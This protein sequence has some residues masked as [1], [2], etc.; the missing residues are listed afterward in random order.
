M[1]ESM[2]A[3]IDETNRRRAGPD[4][5]QRGARHRAATIVKEIHDIN[6]RLRAVAESTQVYAPAERPAT[7]A[8]LGAG[9]REQ[10]ERLVSQ[11]EAEMKNAAKEL[12]FERAAAL[13]DEI[14]Q[15]DCVCSR[16]TVDDRRAG[17]RERGAVR[18]EARTIETLAPERVAGAGGRDENRYAR[19]R[20]I[21][22]PAPEAPAY[23]VTSVAVLPA[24]EEPAATLDGVPHDQRRRGRRRRHRAPTASDWLPGIRDE[25]EED[26]GWQARWTERPTWD[27]TVTPN[28]IRRTGT[29]PPRPGRRRR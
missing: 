12:E 11:L 2:K 20:R 26:G 4:G 24:E 19:P 27:R 23:E 10:V 22:E 25:H 5:L 3:A 29:R 28:V 8:R 16:K 21:G 1:T 13:R 15:S 17:R 7:A 6:E 18:R 9:G 14:Q